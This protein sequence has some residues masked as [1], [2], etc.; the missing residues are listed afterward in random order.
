MNVGSKWLCKDTGIVAVITRVD[1]A[2]GLA[3]WHELDH[4]TK[5][6]HSDLWDWIVWHRWTPYAN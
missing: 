3:Y 5:C 4:P 2:N 1:D 6:W